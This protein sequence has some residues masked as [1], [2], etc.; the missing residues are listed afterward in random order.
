MISTSNS[1]LYY[2][3][4]PPLVFF[5]QHAEICEVPSKIFYEG[6]L[7]THDSV[8]DRRNKE[9]HLHG[10]W[11]RSPQYPIVF[12]DIIGEETQQ[13]TGT[14][15]GNRVGIES[16]HNIIEAQKAVSIEYL[17]LRC[18]KYPAAYFPRLK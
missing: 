2:K 9:A 12:C 8:L 5:L 15:D 11:P 4:F 3:V 18:I 7:Q 13:E 1:V 10:F 17:E 6:K 14:I 16:K